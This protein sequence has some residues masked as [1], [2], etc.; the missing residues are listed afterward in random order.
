MRAKAPSPLRFAGAVHDAPGLAKRMVIAR[1][2][3]DC[4][5]RSPSSK[6]RMMGWNSWNYFG[7]NVSDT[8]IRGI[9]DLMATNGMQAAGYQFINIDD[10]WQV[11]RDTNGV[12][13]PDPTRFPNGIK[14][15][16]DYVHSK[17]FKLGV[18]SDHG[19]ETCQ[20]RPGGYGYEYLDANTYAAW[21]VDYLKYDNCNLPAGDDAEADYLRMADALMSSGRP[22]TFSL[23]HWSMAGVFM[24]ILTETI[25]RPARAIIRSA[26][27]ESP[28]PPLSATIRPMWI[29]AGLHSGQRFSRQLFGVLH[30]ERAGFH[31][32]R[33]ADK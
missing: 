27:R 3:M 18:Y 28:R 11:S 13:M 8:L 6:A 9:A 2:V 32:Q 14:A 10:C 1:G 15:L 25:R 20:G 12:I 31:N 17:G 22:I 4:G 19:L 33:H 24:S 26:A 16:A 7:C 23:C 30:P 5:D 29:S 21:G